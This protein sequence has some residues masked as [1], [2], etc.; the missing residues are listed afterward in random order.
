MIPLYLASGSP[1]RQMLLRQAEIPFIAIEHGTDERAVPIAASLQE[2]VLAIAQAKCHATAVPFSALT[3]TPIFMLTADTMGLGADGT[4]QGKPESPE[5]AA[6]WIRDAR[7]HELQFATAFRLERRIYQHGRW[8][9]QEFR[10]AVAAGSCLFFVPE[11]K[12]DAY[13][14]ESC[15]LACAGAVTIDGYGSR[16]T[17]RID[18]SYTA[19]LGLPMAELYQALTELS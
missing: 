8:I 3:T 18:G 4:I 13:L 14:T 5:Q 17:R 10:E 19:I 7:S 1:T 9:C 2:Q 6:Q 15:A 12:V 16:F 11:D